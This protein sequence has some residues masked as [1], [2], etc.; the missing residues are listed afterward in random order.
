[1]RR[2]HTYKSKKEPCA[3]WMDYLI[4]TEGK[5]LKAVFT[6]VDNHFTDLDLHLKEIT[7]YTR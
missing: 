3:L 1:M 4:E 2:E 5:I 6:K 7:P